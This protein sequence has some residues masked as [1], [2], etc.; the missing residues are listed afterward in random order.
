MAFR[1]Y[2][3]GSTTVALP[4]DVSQGHGGF[5]ARCEARLSLAGNFKAA[6]AK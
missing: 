3:S 1:K 2:C 5:A 4:L 6:T